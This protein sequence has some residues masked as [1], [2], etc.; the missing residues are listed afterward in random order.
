MWRSN[1]SCASN[2]SPNT[3]WNDD[4][5]HCFP[6]LMD[7]P[8]SF[9]ERANFSLSSRWKKLNFFANY[10]CYWMS[11]NWMWM[12]CVCIFLAHERYFFCE[13]LEMAIWIQKDGHECSSGGMIEMGFFFVCVKY[14]RLNFK[15]LSLPVDFVSLK[16][17]PYC[18][19]KKK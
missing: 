13:L 3:G 4:D 14:W 8:I 2:I 9:Y 15:L 10:T 19:Q 1:S 17:I 6:S 12:R 16:F 7:F 5:G 18:T 11:I